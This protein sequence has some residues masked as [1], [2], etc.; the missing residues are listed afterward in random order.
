MFSFLVYT[1]Y[2]IATKLVVDSISTIQTK[3][4]V[5]YPTSSLYTKLLKRDIW[6]KLTL[7]LSL[8]LRLL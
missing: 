2:S 5:I 6:K 4:V 1:F 7:L 8:V 3:L